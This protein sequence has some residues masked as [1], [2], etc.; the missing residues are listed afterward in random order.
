MPTMRCACLACC[1]IW[2]RGRVDV[3]EAITAESVR[4]PSSM[5][6][7]LCLTPISSKTASMTKS[8]LRSS[9]AQFESSSVKP[10]MFA[11]WQ[12]L[13]KGARLLRLTFLSSDAAICASPRARPAGA[14]SLS[15][16]WKP[17]VA[18]TCAMPAPIKPAPSTPIVLT[19]ADGLPYGFF[20]H[21]VCPKKRPCS[22][23]HSGVTASFPNSAASTLEPCACPPSRPARMARRMAGGAGYLPLVCLSAAFSACEKSSA[24]PGGVA[25]SAQSSQPRF[26]PLDGFAAPDARASA[27]ATAVRSSACGST[28]RS[29]RPIFLALS[30]RRLLPVSISGSAACA[31][32]RRGSRCVPPE[33]GRRPSITSGSAR[34]VFAP[35]EATRWWHA[36]ATSRPPPMHAPWMAA[37]TGVRSAAIRSM[38]FWPAVAR[39]DASAAVVHAASILMSAPAIK[40]SGL[41]EMSTAAR[42]ERSASSAVSVSSNSPISFFVSVFI[43][44]PCASSRIMAM[45]SAVTV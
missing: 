35:E 32:M 39:A 4:M 18:E 37:T 40:L 43:R 26:L 36:S 34:V 38:I 30:G 17:L 44:S 22:A 9:G 24:R 15:I 6:T 21:A 2:P 14:V 29:T 11:S 20:L 19:G 7:T 12:S 25:S 16:T 31:P 27:A 5:A 8:A 33:P 1:A 28:T 42:T 13:A 3:F 45:P 41:A 23:A 10:V